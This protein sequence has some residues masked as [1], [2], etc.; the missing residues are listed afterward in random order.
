MRDAARAAARQ[1]EHQGPEDREGQAGRVGR[2]RVQ[3]EAEEEGRGGPERGDLGQRDVDEDHLARDD[4]EAQ[5]G[6]DARE[7]QAHQERHP[8]QREQVARHAASLLHVRA[9]LLE[10]LRDGFHIVVD[11]VQ[12]VSAP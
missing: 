12:I 4:V 1:R 11:G 5:I 8:H 2:P 6:V 9:N 7:H 3:L 10:G